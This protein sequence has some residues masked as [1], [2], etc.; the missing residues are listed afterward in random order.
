[1]SS[2]F[3]LVA[4]PEGETQAMRGRGHAAAERPSCCRSR[5]IDFSEGERERGRG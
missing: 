1:M 2:T 4:R 3:G 5:E